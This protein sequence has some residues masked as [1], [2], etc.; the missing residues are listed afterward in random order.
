[1]LL[2]RDEH[3]LR[4]DLTQVD[5]QLIGRDGQPGPWPAGPQRRAALMAPR[6]PGTHPTRANGECAPPMR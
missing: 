4:T 3:A 6:H 2:E 5:V 1:M